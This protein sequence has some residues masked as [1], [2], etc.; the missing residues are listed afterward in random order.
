MSLLYTAGTVIFLGVLV[1]SLLAM[2]DIISVKPGSKR[3]GK[4]ERQSGA[5]ARREARMARKATLSSQRSDRR[6]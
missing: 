4:S 5:N 3:T 6:S 1:L 2:L